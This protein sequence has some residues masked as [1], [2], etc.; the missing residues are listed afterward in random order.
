MAAEDFEG[1][2]ALAKQK[3]D[4]RVAKTPDRVAY[5][6]QQF[7]KNN[8]EYV[9]K[10]E[11]IGHFHCRSQKTDKLYQFWAG[12]GKIYC[13]SRQGDMLH[14]GIHNLIQLLKTT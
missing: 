7:E 14:R 2:K 13:D 3:H 6:I 9:L 11:K 8:I 10:N 1:I 12:T 5:A 4:A